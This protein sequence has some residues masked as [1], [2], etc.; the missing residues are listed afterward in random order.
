M[1]TFQV[2]NV[3]TILTEGL[4]LLVKHWEM[5]AINKDKIQLKP[6]VA[7]YLELERVGII[8][9]FTAR[10]NGLLVGYIVFFVQPSLHYMDHIFASNDILFIHPDHR[11]GS[12]GIRLIKYAESK[13][14]EQGVSVVMINT[15]THAPF[16]PILNRLGYQNTERLHTKYIG[17]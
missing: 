11:K 13:L 17:G 12:A 9:V 15:K 6:N 3:K 1:I 14:K 2:E 5:I 8:K 16:D 10:D 4:E 7:A